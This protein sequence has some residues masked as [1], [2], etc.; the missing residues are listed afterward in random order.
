MLGNDHDAAD[1]VQDANLRALA[2]FEKLEVSETK[3]WYLTIVRNVCLNALRSRGRLRLTEV[4]EGALEQF[5]HDDQG[6]PARLAT[7]AW[8]AE[9]VRAA[10][11]SLAVDLREII[12]L[13]EFEQL[14]Y[15]EIAEVASLPIGT[16]MSRLS[17]ARNQLL[18]ALEADQQ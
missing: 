10:V 18:K 16:V 13:R 3:S 14:S 17:R 15:R 5:T 1:A 8:E 6:D 12:V 4:P 7:T 9:R 11:D 2:H